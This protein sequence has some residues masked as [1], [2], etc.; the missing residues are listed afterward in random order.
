MLARHPTGTGAH[1]GRGEAGGVIDIHL[2]LLEQQSHGGGEARP[3]LV[4]ELT[5][6]HLGLI[7]ATDRGE[8]YA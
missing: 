5:G 8:A 4:V 7:D 1:I 2:A 6:T 3:I